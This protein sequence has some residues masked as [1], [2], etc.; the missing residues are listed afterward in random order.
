LRRLEEGR[1]DALILACAGLDRLSFGERITLRIPLDEL[2]SAP[3]QGALG[4]SCRRDDAGTAAALATLDDPLTNAAAAAERSLLNA[5][6]AGC[7]A[8]VAALAMPGEA[9]TLV[10]RARVLALDG[11]EMLEDE[12]SGAAADP[13]GLGRLL[14]DRLLSRGAHRL[15]TEARAA[16]R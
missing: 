15:V 9:G 5:L 13:G 1:A 12:A 16:A 3:A 14:A 10:L 7:R 11:S 2:L 6:R 8:P 4:I